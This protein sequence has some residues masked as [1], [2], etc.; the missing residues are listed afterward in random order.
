MFKDIWTTVHSAKDLKI[1]SKHS[2][3]QFDIQA[4]GL[5][6]FPYFFYP[7]S[8]NEVTVALKSNTKVKDFQR[9]WWRF[10]NAELRT[11]I[12][13]YGDSH[14]NKWAAS[15][16]A[17]QYTLIWKSSIKPSYD[18]FL[19][20]TNQLLVLKPKQ[21]IVLPKLKHVFLMLKRVRLNVSTEGKT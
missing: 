11:P 2:N 8:L 21:D 18:P 4:N 15:W 7:T 6:A 9:T 3:D 19:N 13:D 12:R 16:L 10:S 20:L 17:Y 14:G 1:C 5:L